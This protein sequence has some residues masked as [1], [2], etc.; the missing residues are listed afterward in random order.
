MIAMTTGRFGGE[1][2]AE[3]AP[4]TGE[5]SFNVG[6]AADGGVTAGGGVG[7]D[8]GMV[9]DE[10]TISD[11]G[12]TEEGGIVS[13]GGIAKDG[14]ATTEG[15]VAAGAGL[16]CAIS[17]AIAGRWPGSRFKQRRTVSTNSGAI[18][19][20][21]ETSSERSRDHAGGVWVRASTIV[22]P[23]PQASPAVGILPFLASGGSYNDGFAMLAPRS[24]AGRIV[25]LASFN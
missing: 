7:S 12:V 14:G 17:S 3:S 24:P 6:G 16:N 21:S 10:G 4:I 22:M 1:F 15:A 25:S 23:S 5:G 9:A 11:S 18:S 2:F 20:G 8:G 19:A 13:D